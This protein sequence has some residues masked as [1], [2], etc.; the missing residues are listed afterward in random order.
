MKMQPKHIFALPKHS[1]TIDIIRG[2]SAGLIVLYH[3][4][5][6]YNENSLIIAA[7][8]TIKWPLVID[9]GYG[10]VV[11]FFILS[12]YLVSKYLNNKEVIVHEFL[13]KRLLRLYPTFW[14]C[15]T[16][17]AIFT[18]FFF[19]ES[20]ISIYDFFIN[21]T[22]VPGVFRSRLIDG[23]YWTMAYEVKFA[24]L[25]S[26]ILLHRN[27]SVRKTLLL[28][29]VIVSI[30]ASFSAQNETLL[31][32]FLRA[33][34]ITDWAQIFLIGICIF[35]LQCRKGSFYY[36]LLLLCFV[37]QMLWHFSHVH[38]IFLLITTLFLI[39]LPYI[40]KL[41]FPGFINPIYK[42]IR[43][44]A[45]I[46]YPLYLLHQMI[47]FAV[48]KNLQQLGLTSEFWLFLPAGLSILLGYM[49]HR[50][51]EIPTS[52]MRSSENSEIT[53]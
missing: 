25:Y 30:L 3:Y 12:G 22:M 36:L 49:V 16:I 43:F 20:K 37:N 31:F 50:F 1:K 38:H 18:L 14:V 44:I 35:Q 21:L 53:R 46:S 11:T 41:N 17:T 19:P 39:C 9:W 40:E 4:T 5:C 47:G 13:K 23:A 24:I 15:M 51:V 28:F 34:L 7:N 45:L 29:W 32:K 52:R 8:S 33:F 42:S 6:R 2:I 10:A 27:I 48:I 26:I